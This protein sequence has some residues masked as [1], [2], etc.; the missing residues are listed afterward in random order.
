MSSTEILI[1]LIETHEM[2]YCCL[3]DDSCSIENW[4]TL[5]VKNCISRIYFAITTSGSGIFVIPKKNCNN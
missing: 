4:M 1:R 3:N 5:E 2:K